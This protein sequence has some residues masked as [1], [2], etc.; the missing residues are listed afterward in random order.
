LAKGVQSI[1]FILGGGMLFFNSRKWFIREKVI[2]D[3]RSFFGVGIFSIE[4]GVITADS[5][6]TIQIHRGRHEA[7]S[8]LE[9]IG[10]DSYSVF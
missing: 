7:V 4:K 6:I 3:S 10:K 5:K 9:G 8:S 1:G 2:Y